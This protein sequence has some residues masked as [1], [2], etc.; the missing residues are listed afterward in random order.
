[1]LQGEI[2]AGRL[3]AAAA[4]RDR[5]AVARPSATL[6][7]FIITIAAG[8]YTLLLALHLRAS[9][10]AGLGGRTTRRTTRAA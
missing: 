1:M 3:D 7:G 6:A 5:F 2:E 10:S 4:S 8:H 9:A